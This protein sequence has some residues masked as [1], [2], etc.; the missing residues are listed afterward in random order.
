MN[1]TKSRTALIVGIGVAVIAGGL[2]A[3]TALAQTAPPSRLP[4][5]GY[6]MGSGHMGGYG[7]MEDNAYGDFDHEGMHNWMWATGAR[8]VHT[9]VWD[10]LADG[11]GLTTEDLEAELASGNTLVE[12]AAARGVSQDE[13]AAALETSMA[14]GLD[15]AVADG[16]VTEEQADWMLEQM[17]GDYLWILD[18]MGAGFMGGYGGCHTNAGELQTG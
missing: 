9:L 16:V 11:L 12:I 4:W 7:M 8:S 1:N 10:G 2:L 18:H 15:Q 6:G 3:G 17:G 13:L 14:A 5:G